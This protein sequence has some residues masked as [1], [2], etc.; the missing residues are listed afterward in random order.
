MLPQTE[1]VEAVVV[2]DVDSGSVVDQQLNGLSVVRPHGLEQR[3]LPEPV[4]GVRIG[5]VGNQKPGDLQSEA[6]EGKPVT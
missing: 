1:Q 5:P 4:E 6:I 3:V 2:G